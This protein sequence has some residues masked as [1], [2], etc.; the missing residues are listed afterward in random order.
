MVRKKKQLEEEKGPHINMPPD[1][2][3]FPSLQYRS[4]SEIKDLP[5]SECFSLRN[6]TTRAIVAVEMHNN[7]G[8]FLTEMSL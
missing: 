8:I 7:S 4:E 1:N 3:V 5:Y 2:H 6:R